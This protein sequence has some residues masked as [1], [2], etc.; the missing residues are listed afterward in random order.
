MSRRCGRRRPPWHIALTT[1]N[2]RSEDGFTFLEM[3]I[4]ITILPIVVGAITAAFLVGLHV[5]GGATG[6]NA[7]NI[8]SQDQGRQIAEATFPQDAESAG[9]TASCPT[10]VIYS[11]LPSATN[12]NPCGSTAYASALTLCTSVSNPTSGT[13]TALAA[14][15][16]VVLELT[17]QGVPNITTS[18]GAPPVTTM[19]TYQVDYLIQSVS[20]VALNTGSEGAWVAGGLSPPV[21]VPTTPS[22]PTMN[23]TAVELIR[24]YCDA[25][26]PANNSA[27]VVS[28]GLNNGYDIGNAGVCYLLPAWS[29]ANEGAVTL[30][31][32]DTSC[33][34]YSLTGEEHS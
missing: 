5:I 3:L 13:S 30:N 23:T 26:T 11:G 22:P 4:V 17:W 34:P 27:M 32:T 12:T 10:G 21:G 2:G 16:L 18:D 14:D 25:S 8:L 7:N 20:G 24:L 1:R 15:Q 29:S 19:D 31:L 28:R 9:P 6:N 33:T